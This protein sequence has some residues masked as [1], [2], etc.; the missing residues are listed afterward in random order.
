MEY[1]LYET[2][3][4]FFIYAFLGWCVEVIYAGLADGRVVNRGFLNGPVCPIYGVGM[5]GVL[6]LLGPVQERLFLLFFLGMLLCSVIELIGGWVLEKVFH[7]R[8]WDYSNMPLQLGGYVCLGF[9][10]LWGLAVVFVVRLI[11]PMIMGLIHWMPP[12]LGIILLPVF[13]V[14]FL[15]DF[16]MTVKT[17]VGLKKQLGE[18]ERLASALHGLSDSLSEKLGSSAIAADSRLDEMKEAGQ[19]KLSEMKEAGQGKLSEQKER[20]ETYVNATRQ[21]L[22]EKKQQLEARKNELLES[23]RNAPRFGV[24]RLSSAFPTVRDSLREKLDRLSK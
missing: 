23:M 2:A 3:W 17:I 11:Q 24:R 14:L 12:M 1:T 7:T 5:L 13:S 18:L 21:E 15:V 19:E 9:S 16:I 20:M 8:W 4:L 6:F 10:I 22:S